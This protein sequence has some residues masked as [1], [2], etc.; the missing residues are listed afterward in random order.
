[1]PMN[2]PKSDSDV[3]GD[4]HP[5]LRQLASSGKHPSAALLRA[6][7]EGVLPAEPDSAICSH[8]ASC[9]A[10]ASLQDDLM[11]L[12][13]LGPSSDQKMR[14]RARMPVEDRRGGRGQAIRWWRVALIGAV[15]ALFVV[16]AVLTHRQRTPLA[17]PV[18]KAPIEIP[19]TMLPMRGASQL[20]QPDLQRWT[21]ALRPYKNDDFPGAIAALEKVARDYPRFA[22]AYFYLGVSQLMLGRNADA[23]VQ[24]ARARELSS[25]ERRIEASWYLGVADVRLGRTAEAA[26]L[27][28]SVCAAGGAYAP[29][30]CNANQRLKPANPQ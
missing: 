1:M 26:G 5:L 2:R 14:I 23:A 6:S 4:D 11:E 10:C 22:D 9:P 27:W 16:A 12:E 24:L 15:A 25:G 18:S 3:P 21:E 29:Q 7:R 30:A 8:V 28:Q 17:A 20:G 19:A 13:P